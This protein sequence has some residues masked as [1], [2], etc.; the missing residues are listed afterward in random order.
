MDY[1]PKPEEYL[2]SLAVAMAARSNCRKRAVGAIITSERRIIAAGYNGTIMGFTNCF[3]GGCPRCN[4]DAPSG[5]LLDQCI[6][7]HAEQNALLSAAQLNNGVKGGECWVTTE[8]CLDCTKSLIQAK[9]ASTYYLQPYP[10]TGGSQTLRDDMRRHALDKR[11]IHFTLWQPDSDVLKLNDQIK[12]I[13]ER[14]A[15]YVAAHAP[16]ITTGGQ[17]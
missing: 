2:M 15:A 11:D 8:P 16:P 6:C 4:S 12:E 17:P 5:T 7:V 13:N 9:V 1:R 14:L 3:D 10:L